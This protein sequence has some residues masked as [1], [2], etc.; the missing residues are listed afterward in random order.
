MRP[1]PTDKQVESGA[2]VMRDTL[3][4]VFPFYLSTSDKALLSAGFRFG[5]TWMLSSTTKEFSREIKKHTKTK[6]NDL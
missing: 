2:A 4:A 6:K 5:I 3:D 1:G